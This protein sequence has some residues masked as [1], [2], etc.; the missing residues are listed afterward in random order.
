MVNLQEFAQN[1]MFIYSNNSG[2]IDGRL[3]GDIVTRVQKHLEDTEPG[4]KL[5]IMDRA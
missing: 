3:F 4:M 2:W 5:L 1:R